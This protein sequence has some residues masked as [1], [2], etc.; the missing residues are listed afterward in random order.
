MTITPD[1]GTPT[2]RPD[3][4]SLMRLPVGA[5]SPLWGLYAGAAVGGMAL[6][7]MSR[8]ARPQNLEAFFGASA[9]TPA[10]EPAPALIAAPVVEAW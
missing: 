2:A 3:P 6:W 10:P 1:T 4:E 7:L 8:W 9:P 5:V